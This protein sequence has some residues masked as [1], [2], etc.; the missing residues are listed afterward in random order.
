M[1]NVIERSVI[2][3]PGSVL[4]VPIPDLISSAGPL[5]R[6]PHV[7]EAMERSQILQALRE[8]GGKVAGSDGAAVRLGMRRTTLQSRM[9]R[10]HIERQYR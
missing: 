3:S 5:V 9:K 7:D 1:Q 6:H 2:L 8:S 4:E 10:L